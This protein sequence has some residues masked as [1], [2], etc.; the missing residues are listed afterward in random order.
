MVVARP[1]FGSGPLAG[2]LVGSETSFYVTS[3]IGTIS[4]SGHVNGQLISG[5]Y[6]VARSDNVSEEGTFVLRKFKSIGPERKFDPNSCPTDSEMT[7]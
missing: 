7:Q 3:E 2:F 4:F 1:L 6:S 5:R